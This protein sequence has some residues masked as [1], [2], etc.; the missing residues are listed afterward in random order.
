MNSL[1]VKNN[2]EAT[3]ISLD[4]DRIYTLKLLNEYNEKLKKKKKEFSILDKETRKAENTFNGLKEVHEKALNSYRE[5]FEEEK[6]KN[7]NETELKAKQIKKEHDDYVEKL[8]WL[9]EKI[10]NGRNYDEKLDLKI[11]ESEQLLESRSELNNVVLSLKDILESL[12]KEESIILHR[13][14]DAKNDYQIIISS[15]NDEIEKVQ[16]RLTEAKKE[17]IDIEYKT[18]SFDT[19]LARKKKDLSIIVSRIEKKY[20][21]EFPNLKMNL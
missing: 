9:N 15:G 11:K 13:I 3:I 20:G 1:V 16:K 7:K 4:K 10:E 2:L 5:N 8:S 19:D 17:L 12:K 18:R 14:Q 21:E 6:R